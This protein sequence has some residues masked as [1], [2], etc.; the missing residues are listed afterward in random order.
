MGDEQKDDEQ[1]DEQEENFYDD[2]EELMVY[3]QKDYDDAEELMTQNEA[4][5]TRDYELARQW[6]RQHPEVD[7]KGNSPSRITFCPLGEKENPGSSSSSSI[8][9]LV[10]QMEA[11]SASE[12][13]ANAERSE[14]GE[15][16]KHG[17]EAMKDP[18]CGGIYLLNSPG[19]EEASR[20]HA[21]QIARPRRQEGKYM[22]RSKGP[23]TAMGRSKGKY[24]DRSE[25][26]AKTPTLV[27]A[28]ENYGVRAAAEAAAEKAYIRAV[29]K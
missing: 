19:G 29:R 8:P 2:E 9:K 26:T 18:T 20:R 25:R 24:L 27:P 1:M 21:E 4:K 13:R 22:D 16:R 7:E 14:M 23:T 6:E 3:T 17:V 11:R 15:E 28:A 5:E 12:R 10:E